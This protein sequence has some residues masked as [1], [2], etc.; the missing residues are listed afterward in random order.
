M[1]SMPPGN[2]VH[3]SEAHRQFVRVRL[4]GKVEVLHAD[5]SASI[6]DVVDL[7]AGG[8][9]LQQNESELAI[10]PLYEGKL[11]L[12]YD[13][14]AYAINIRFQVKIA[15]DGR[16]GC[17]FQDIGPREGDA[18]RAIIGAY[19]AGEVVDINDMLH[20]VQRDNAANKRK[21]AG[22]EASVGVRAAAMIGTLSIL[23]L[24]L[25]AFGYVASQVYQVLLVNSSASAMVTTNVEFL[26]MPVDGTFNSLLE[27]GQRHV[28]KGLP[29]GT[30]EEASAPVVG[31]RPAPR[32]QVTLLS[33]CDCDVVGLPLGDVAVLRKGDPVVQ[34][35][36]QDT[37]RWVAALFTVEQAQRLRVGDVVRVSFDNHD[38]AT[39]GRISQID[40]ARLDNVQ[41]ADNFVRIAVE[42][43]GQLPAS[44]LGQPGLVAR[45]PALV[46]K[47]LSA[48]GG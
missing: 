32:R 6:F 3:E 27:P 34:L 29:L 24:G 37:K 17:V 36:R 45:H 23:L 20:V 41:V 8:V 47:L 1:T 7:S 33:P 48:W 21:T 19:L 18:I 14:F 11:H 30:Y 25:L 12:Q 44:A 13:S 40:A 16:Y 43:N 5:G 38:L 2:I 26:R 4:P 22:A 39:L 15:G 28:R 46:M 9:S 10:G 35:R 31:A 42:V